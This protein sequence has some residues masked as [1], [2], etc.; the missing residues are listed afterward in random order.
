MRRAIALAA[1]VL[2]IGAAAVRADK[3]V[4]IEIQADDRQVERGLDKAGEATD[5]AL[6]TAGR[7]VNRALDTASHAVDYALEVARA[8]TGQ[9]L[10]KT[11]EGMQSAGQ[12]VERTGEQMRDN[13][14]VQDEGRNEAG[15]QVQEEVD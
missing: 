13:V 9:A 3:R 10:D 14:P 6:D 12:A 15:R 7:A 1:A 4:A 5:R 2:L 11:G 8:A